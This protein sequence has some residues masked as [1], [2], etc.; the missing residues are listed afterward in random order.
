MITAFRP[1]RPSLLPDRLGTIGAYLQRELIDAGRI[2]GCQ[3]LVARAGRIAMFDQ[4]G[5]ADLERGVAM[6]NDTIFRLATLTMPLTATALMILFDEGRFHLDD[7]V[8]RHLP[9][10]GNHRVHV[11]GAGAHMVTEPPQRPVT[12]HDLLRHTAGLSCG[13]ACGGLE[14][15]GDAHHHSDEAATL[16]RDES[17]MAFL[18][19]IAQMPL[20]HHPGHAWDYALSYDIIGA[21]VERLAGEPFEDFLRRRLWQPLGM[22][23]TGFHVPEDRLHRFAAGYHRGAHGRIAACDDPHSSAFRTRPR[24]GS[25]ANGMVGTATDYFRFCEMIRRGGELDGTRIL[26]ARAVRLMLANHLPGGGDIA[27]L[28]CEGHVERGTTGIGQGLGF[29]MT[30]DAIGAGSLATHDI[31]WSGFGSSLFWID[32]VDQLTVV[33]MSQFT[34]ARIHDFHRPLRTLVYAALPH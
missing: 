9:M 29:A 24:F 17:A 10:F 21:L 31:F 13:C 2:A 33:F 26:S 25:G 34:P 7:P 23:D 6:G 12:I 16:R 4:W 3:L 27:S 32:P 20:R 22:V 30:L 11:S 19:R 28:S 5:W 1:D 18:Q 14:S 15:A 8:H